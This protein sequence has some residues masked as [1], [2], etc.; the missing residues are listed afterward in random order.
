MNANPIDKTCEQLL[1]RTSQVLK[2]LNVSRATL[3]KAQKSKSFPKPIYINKDR[4]LWVKTD[5]I[6]WIELEK[7]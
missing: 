1:L 5:L 3:K 7:N 4:P 2:M 6:K